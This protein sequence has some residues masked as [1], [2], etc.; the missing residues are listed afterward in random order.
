[1]KKMFFTIIA[2][3]CFTIIVSFYWNS[4]KIK[5]AGE[6][7][8]Y[9]DPGPLD[10]FQNLWKSQRY[11][12]RVD[13]KPLTV[14][15]SRN[16]TGNDIDGKPIP[17]GYI[18]EAHFCYFS[19][20][21]KVVTIEI[22]SP[23]GSA[24]SHA[25]VHPLR[26]KI[27]CN[28][29]NGRIILRLEKPCKLVVKTSNDELYPLIILTDAPDMD[30]PSG[31]NVTR[32]GPG[33]HDIGLQ[34]K[35]HDNEIIYIDG[36]AVVKGTFYKPK[37]EGSLKNFTMRG[38]GIVYAGDY[39][40]LPQQKGW[41][42][43]IT[44][45]EAGLEDG[46]IEGC[47]FVDGVH[48]N[49][50]FRNSGTSFINLKM[51][52]WHGNTDGVRVGPNSSCHDCFVM[53][54]DDS[55]LPEG[56]FPKGTSALFE[57]CVVWHHAWGSPFKI[58]NLT[59]RNSEGVHDLTYRNIDILETGNASVFQSPNTRR[60]IEPI[61]L[62]PNQKN[63]LV[64]PAGPTYNILFEKIYIERAERLFEL[65]PPGENALSNITFRN[66]YAPVAN[67]IIEGWD[68]ENCI[69]NITFDNLVINGK[70]IHSLDETQ[71]ILGKFV[72]NV[73][74]KAQ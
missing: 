48:W 59:S 34:R 1:M 3:F 21:D 7:V 46:L 29:E 15:A 6:V 38:R 19:F 23:D 56:D 13:G 66:I 65:R 50:G 26:L 31:P 74:V 72:K 60:G 33:V 36:G 12:V 8:I 55:L 30:I 18:S 28:T 70:P 67:G 24:Y 11:V 68:D 37:Q 43:G 57:D 41:G 40:Y 54:N 5:D 14:Y 47:I 64:R 32:F 58:I 4:N 22:S 44:G 42:R 20:R 52:C 69:Q 71:I 45:W 39:E 27:P 16:R 17:K 49:T 73:K 61:V 10:Q 25:S 9:P 62:A 2:L 35:I 53:T 63:N 51:I